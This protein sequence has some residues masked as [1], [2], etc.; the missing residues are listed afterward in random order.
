MLKKLWLTA[1]ITFCAWRN[2]RHIALAE[3]WLERW[4]KAR[5]KMH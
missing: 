1:W 4:S 5:E 3:A 2:D